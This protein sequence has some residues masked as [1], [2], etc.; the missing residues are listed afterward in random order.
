MKIPLEV[1]IYRHSMKISLAVLIYR[2]YLLR[3][4]LRDHTLI[5]CIGTKEK[6]LHKMAIFSEHCK[7]ADD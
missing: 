7:F 4:V 3:N 2:P 5:Y 1:L 6:Y